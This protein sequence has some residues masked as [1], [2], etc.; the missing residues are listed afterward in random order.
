ME[1]TVISEVRHYCNGKRQ[2]D[3]RVLESG[4]I[5]WENDIKYCPFCGVELPVNIGRTSSTIGRANES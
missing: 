1:G 2:E 4:N 3:G 5:W